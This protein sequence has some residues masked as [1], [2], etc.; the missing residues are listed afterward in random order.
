MTTEIG[1]NRPSTTNHATVALFCG[2]AEADASHARRLETALATLK[3][4]GLLH[5]W[6]ERSLAPGE[7]VAQSTMR[8]LDS[9][10]LTLLLLSP[11]FLASDHC[12]NALLE[13]ALSNHSAGTQTVVPLL[14]RPCDWSH[15]PIGTLSPLPKTNDATVLPISQWPDP[16]SAWQ[17]VTEGVREII[18]GLIPSQLA[19]ANPSPLSSSSSYEVAPGDPRSAPEGQWTFVV[20]G[21]ISDYDR[22]T[23]E[24][25]IEHLRKLSGDARLTL[26]RVEEGSVRI[27]LR[28]TRVGF[29]KLTRLHQEG[30]LAPSLNVTVQELEWNAIEDIDS[31]PAPTTDNL[32]PHNAASPSATDAQPQHKL[33]T[34]ETEQILAHLAAGKPAEALKLL[35]VNY[36]RTLLA[37]L[38]RVTK[39]REAAEDVL[40]DVF[41]DAYRRLNHEQFG[42]SVELPGGYFRGLLLRIARNRALDLRRAPRTEVPP[43][44]DTP[45]RVVPDSTS[46]QP[47]LIARQLLSSAF[48]GTTIGVKNIHTGRRGGAEQN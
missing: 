9:A 2:Y 20:T 18:V 4:Q 29:E 40:Q 24:A 10:N 12:Y 42:G 46:S 14:V 3:R 34:T 8:A 5:T 43:S 28:G 21:S 11:D 6:S 26:I 15:T 35:Y 25:L 44:E 19:S 31:S 13:K 45:E 16:D 48:G 30:R 7:N 33:A 39:S 47:E 1:H 23:L 36:S 22:R 27:V 17:S 32:S 38:L 41:I 37:Y